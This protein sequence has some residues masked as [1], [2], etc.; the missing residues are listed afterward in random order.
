MDATDFIQ[1]GI[2]LLGRGAE[3]ETRTAVSRLYYGVFHVAS[4]ILWNKCGIEIPQDQAHAKVPHLFWQAEDPKLE[5]VG[6]Q[7]NSLRKMR[8]IADYDLKDSQ[9]RQ[10]TWGQEQLLLTQEILQALSDCSSSHEFPTSTEN[11]RRYARDVL[12]LNLRNLE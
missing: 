2:K 8:R 6:R 9:P 3:A 4:G 7:L 1:L 5:Q 12:R 10:A 11:I